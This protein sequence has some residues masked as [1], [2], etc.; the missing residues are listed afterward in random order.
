M[1]A[2]NARHLL[3]FESKNANIFN[4][5]AYIKF[6]EQKKA[7]GCQSLVDWAALEMRYPDLSGS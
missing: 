2:V 4:I 1:N 5:R 7:E 6:Y 3:I